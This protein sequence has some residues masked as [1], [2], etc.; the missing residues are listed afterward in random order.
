MSF[1]SIWIQVSYFIWKNVFFLQSTFKAKKCKER[2]IVRKW[3]L[4]VV[5]LLELVT[6]LVREFVILAYL[7][8]FVITCSSAVQLA[9]VMSVLAI[10]F[11]IKVAYRVNIANEYMK[12]HIQLYLNKKKD[13]NL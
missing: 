5:S 7:C 1:D 11:P 2:Y 6:S 3:L 9:F 12:D 13:M 10:V 8:S 4:I